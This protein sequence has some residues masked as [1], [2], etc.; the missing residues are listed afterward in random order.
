ML[1]SAEERAVLALILEM[2]MIKLLGELLLLKMRFHGKLLWSARMV[3]GW[4]VVPY[5]SVV[6]QSSSSL[7]LIVSPDLST[8]SKILILI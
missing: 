3:V 6:I 4:A 8:H 1:Q 7:R 2:Q 5:F